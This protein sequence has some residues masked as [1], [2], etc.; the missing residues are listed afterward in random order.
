MSPPQSSRTCVPDAPVSSLTLAPSQAGLGRRQLVSTAQARRVSRIWS[1]LYPFPL[2]LG[3]MSR[4]RQQRHVLTLKTWF[5]AAHQLSKQ[6]DADSEMY[7]AVTVL[8]E[9]LRKEVQDLGIEGH[10]CHRTR[11]LPHQLPQLWPQNPSYRRHDIAPT[12][13]SL[14]ILVALYLRASTLLP[15]TNR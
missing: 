10:D 5:A 15:R 8:T 2:Y 1:I 11:L 6:S 13:P 9:S 3:V 4:D 14:G 7:S 12:V